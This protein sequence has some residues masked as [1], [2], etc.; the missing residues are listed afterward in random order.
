MGKIFFVSTLIILLF[1]SI[2]FISHNDSLSPEGQIIYAIGPSVY[3]IDLKNK[4]IEKVYTDEEE[5]HV[6]SIGNINDHRLLLGIEDIEEGNFIVDFDIKT[7]KAEVLGKGSSPLYMPLYKKVFFFTLGKLNVASIDN[8][9]KAAESVK[10]CKSDYN[11]VIQVSKKE[12]VFSDYDKSGS[13]NAW[14][15]N[16][17][18]KDIELL[19]LQNYISPQLWRN[20]TKQL[21]CFDRE[22]KNYF[23]IDLLGNERQEIKLGPYSTPV[24][25]L[26]ET[27][28]LILLEGTIR[29]FAE[30]HD[31]WIY[32]FKTDKK[33]LISKSNGFAL[34]AGVYLPN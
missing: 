7:R 31:L 29:G 10:R 33:E 32:D 26:P 24:L 34:G 20:E 17:E 28:Q 3:A 16:I 21:I 6:M 2:K 22:Q 30:I 23:L 27:D 1:I 19:P 8:F 5:R 18:T 13:N 9:D 12:V 14:L 25:Y 11:H 4:E 15:Y